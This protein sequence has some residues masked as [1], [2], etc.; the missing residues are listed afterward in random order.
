MLLT[1]LDRL[2]QTLQSALGPA[3]ITA[4]AES[5][6]RHRVDG[7]TPRLVVTPESSEQIGAALHHC[8][9]ARATVVPWGGGTAMSLGN[10]PRQLDVVMN[11]GKLNRVVEHDADNLTVSA[12]CGVTLAALRSVLYP[13][14]QFLPIDGPFPERATIGGIAAAN[15]NGPRRSSYGSVRDL[16]I[17]LKVSLAGGESIKAGGKVVKNVAGYDMCK[18]FVGSLGTLGIITEV[19][20]RLAPIAESAATFIVHGTRTQV[21]GFIDELS[22]SAL[23]PAAIFLL[24]EKTQGD[25]RV[26]I[27]CEGFAQGVE[28]HLRDL[29]A[30]AG[31]GKLIY[32]VAGPENHNA[33]WNKLR[34][35]PFEPHRIVYRITVPRSAIS[36]FINRAQAWDVTEIVSDT[37]MG[38]IWL[39]LPVDRTA[40]AQFA[41]ME[42]AACQAGGHAILFSAPGSLKTGINVWGKSPETLSLMREIKRGFDPNGLLNPG[43]FLSAI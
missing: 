38:T 10:P 34:D 7:I 41:E 22:R 25:W 42:S 17:G 28:R 9:A 26:A 13:A 19:T 39:G 16:V 2:T 35:F 18:L 15:L 32:E 20:L 40:I 4:E 12:Q 36:D 24:G 3:A 23:L 43:R 1:S 33:L 30:M 31:R 37:S 14:K 6:S 21:R 11:L 29:Q 27:W 8:S 5:L